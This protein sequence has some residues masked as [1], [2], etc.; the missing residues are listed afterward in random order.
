MDEDLERVYK[1]IHNTTSRE[2]IETLGE[3]KTNLLIMKIIEAFK[4][5]K[6]LKNI[7]ITEFKMSSNENK[8]GE[9]IFFV[10]ASFL[11]H[12]FGQIDYFAFDANGNYLGCVKTSI[13]NVIPPNQVEME[14]WANQ[15][16][17][18]QGNMTVLTREV[19]KEIFN[20]FYYI[21]PK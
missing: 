7:E 14:Y 8:N 4:G 15:E 5:T 19:I 3:Y 6:W 1:E 21:V 9:K 10:R 16:H 11:K 13:C 2:V 12:G 17:V 18:N 20:Y